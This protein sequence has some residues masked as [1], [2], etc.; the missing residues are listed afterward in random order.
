MQLYVLWFRQK[1]FIIMATVESVLNAWAFQFEY[2]F[3][4]QFINSKLTQQFQ[5]QFRIISFSCYGGFNRTLDLRV[6][7]R[8]LYLWATRTQ[9]E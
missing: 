8:A 4:I 5:V 7:S 6:T 9:L 3:I 1:S 2:F